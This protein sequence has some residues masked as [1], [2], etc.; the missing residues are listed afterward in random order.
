MQ[1]AYHEKHKTKRN[2][3]SRRW[4][5]KNADKKHA[6]G[7]QWHIDNAERSKANNAKWKAEN[8]ELIKQKKAAYRADPINREAERKANLA[9]REKHSERLREYSRKWRE[10]RKVERALHQRRRDALKANSNGRVSKFEILDLWKKQ[11]GLC[12]FFSSCGNELKEG[13]R[14]EWHADHIE[15]L[16]P[17]NKSNAPGSNTIDNIQLLCGS[18]NSRKNNKDPYRFAQENGLLFCDIVG[19]PKDQ[20]KRRV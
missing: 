11:N 2:E 9:Y 19:I 15:P 14:R 13:I 7:R 12:V 1:R 4:R 16:R 3:E 8:K 10:S 18:C 17:Q 5:E 20:L 6:D